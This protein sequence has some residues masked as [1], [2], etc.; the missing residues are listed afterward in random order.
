MLQQALG[1]KDANPFNTIVTP[2]GRVFVQNP[3]GVLGIDAAAVATGGAEVKPA[4]K[5]V[6]G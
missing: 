1:L 6:A 5:S 4:R 2:A 3:G